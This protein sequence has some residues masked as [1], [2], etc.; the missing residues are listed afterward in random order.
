MVAEMHYNKLY[1]FLQDG[2]FHKNTR[3][4][5]RVMDDKKYLDDYMGHRVIGSE[6]TEVEMWASAERRKGWF[7]D[8]YIAYVWHVARNKKSTYHYKIE[9]AKEVYDLLKMFYER[10]EK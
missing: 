3:H 5:D 4:P 8:K 6:E 7:G 10:Q 9:S 1:S 2:K